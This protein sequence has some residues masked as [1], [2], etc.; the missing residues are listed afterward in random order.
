MSKQVTA[1][2]RVTKAREAKRPKTLDYINAIFDDFIELHG[3]R[4]YGDDPSFVC[5]IAYLDEMPVTI[6]GQQKGKTTRE[7]MKRNFGM[8][9]P[10]GYRKAIRLM[11]QA[12]K[13]GRPV[14]TFIDT[15]GAYPGMG[16]EERGQGEAIASSMFTMSN[17]KVPI[18]A[19][20]IGEGSSGGALAI[21]LGR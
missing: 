2:E 21:R 9:E 16:A 17:L 19:V 10:E 4:N 12:E 1:W 14:I 5:G 11:K 20:V 6:I 3:D 18:I 7:N 15:P 8:P 13:F